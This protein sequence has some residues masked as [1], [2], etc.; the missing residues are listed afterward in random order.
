M[1]SSHQ[2]PPSSRERPCQQP[3]PHSSTETAAN[4]VPTAPSEPRNLSEGATQGADMHPG[5]PYHR[6]PSP[7]TPEKAQWSNEWTSGHRQAGSGFLYLVEHDSQR[8]LSCFRTLSKTK[9]EKTKVNVCVLATDI[10]VS[11]G[12]SA[13]GQAS[14]RR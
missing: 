12:Q 6:A 3:C 2:R 8:S 5:S 14:R 10:S 9:E 11:V 4:P 1:E 13:L 7:A